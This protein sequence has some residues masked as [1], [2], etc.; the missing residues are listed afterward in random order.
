MTA[1]AP[2][3]I[4]IF[5]PFV[6]VYVDPEPT[7][8]PLIFPVPEIIFPDKESEA[9]VKDATQ[10]KVAAQGKGL[11][12]YYGVLGAKSYETSELIALPNKL[13]APTSQSI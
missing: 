13:D 8:I 4:T 5:S 7:S 9:S 12:T 2:A 6:M 11:L 1:L 3:L 10:F